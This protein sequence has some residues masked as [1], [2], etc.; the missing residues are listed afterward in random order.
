VPKGEDAL[1]E[2][3]RGRFAADDSRVLIGIGDDAAAVRLDGTLVA[4][5]ADMLLDGVHF[6]TH[7]HGFDLVGRKAIACS[8]SD[9]AAMACAPR[10]ATVS[11]ALPETMSLHDAK[12]LYEG[13]AGIAGEFGCAIV[14]GDITSWRGKLAIDVAMLAEPMS[15]RG[16]VRRSDARIGDTIYVSGLLGGSLAGKHLTFTPRI[17]LASRLACEPDLHAMMD[18]SDGL[19][20]DL[21]RLATASGCDAELDARELEQVVSDAARRLSQKDSTPP[22]EHALS[23]GEDFE[24]LA[25]GGSRLEQGQFGLIRIGR[26]V[27]RATLDQ[28]AIFIC[29]ETGRRQPVERR[30]YEHFK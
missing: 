25:V 30:G 29:D 14:G 23:D 8:L 11:V 20:L 26:I 7:Q 9:C 12:Q 21:H 13:M 6:D 19:A 4:I 1:V 17:E 10:V 2:W 27:P 28:S 3:L 22:L 5:T 16:P 18:I 15:A 24:L